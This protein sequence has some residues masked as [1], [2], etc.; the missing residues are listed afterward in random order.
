MIKLDTY[1]KGAAYKLA[2]SKL[3]S[4][5]VA[6]GE[7]VPL[8]TNNIPNMALPLGSIKKLVVKITPLTSPDAVLRPSTPTL[9]PVTK[10]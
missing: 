10:A 2:A 1:A 8:W 9:P 5:C 4:P 7:N 3:T 6:A